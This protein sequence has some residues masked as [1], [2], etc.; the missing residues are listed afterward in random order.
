MAASDWCAVQVWPLIVF[1]ISSNAF[2]FIITIIII[3]FFNYFTIQLRVGLIL[4]DCTSCFLVNSKC[5]GT[6]I[7]FFFT[8][9]EG[10]KNYFRYRTEWHQLSN[11][12][13]RLVKDF[14]NYTFPNSKLLP[15]P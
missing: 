15:A 4:S 2:V 10:K 13:S 7:K 12:P 1:N 3:L 8:Y 6:E 9:P 11:E 14:E 5:N